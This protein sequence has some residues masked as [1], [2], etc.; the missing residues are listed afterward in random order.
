MVD[1]LSVAESIQRIIDGRLD[2][3]NTAIPARVVRYNESEQTVDVEIPFKDV[4]DIDGKDDLQESGYPELP[5]VPIVFQRAGN[6]SITFPL[7]PG[8]NV[9]LIF[10]QRSI[11][12]WYN[13]D[14]S[15]TVEPQ[16]I[17]AHDISDAFAIPGPP[18]NKTQLDGA[19]TSGTNLILRHTDGTKLELTTDNKINMTIDRLNIGS[20]TASTALAKGQ[21]TTDQIAALKTRVD[22][23]SAILSLPPVVLLGTINSSRAFTND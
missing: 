1:Y 6:W 15:V 11:D 5:D 17:R 14:G 13:T 23:L 18:T 7:N 2:A 9:L 21:V 22:T 10:A 12:D 20:D 8:D 3:V 4:Q 16:D 19:A